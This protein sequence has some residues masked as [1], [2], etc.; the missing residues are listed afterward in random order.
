M[1]L[2]PLHTQT[3]T[4]TRLASHAGL[5]ITQI[6]LILYNVWH[7][8]LF[9]CPCLTSMFVLHSLL[10]R[11][12]APLFH[13]LSFS[14]FINAPHQECCCCCCVCLRSPSNESMCQK[15]FISPYHP[16]S[17]FCTTPDN[18]ATS[19][20]QK[21]KH[22]AGQV[23]FVSVDLLISSNKSKSFATTIVVQLL[24]RVQRLLYPV[25]VK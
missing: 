7:C 4:Y 21:S 22:C 17:L 14:S 23:A 15:E 3:H 1:H 20:K 5:K 19:P 25:N 13:T 6:Y 18:G 16:P 8:C 2:I 10:P 24:D 9:S 12:R 11:T